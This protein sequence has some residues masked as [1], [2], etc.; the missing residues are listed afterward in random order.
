VDLL[1]S[2]L[3]FALLALCCGESRAWT[4][5]DI[6][7]VE[8]S[9]TGQVTLVIFGGTQCAPVDWAVQMAAAP[10]QRDYP[11][12]QVLLLFP[13]DTAAAVA[14]WRRRVPGASNTCPA[15]VFLLDEACESWW[16][17]GCRIPLTILYDV[18]GRPLRQWISYHPR[19]EIEP[20]LTR[21]LLDL[22]AS[23]SQFSILNS[24]FPRRSCAVAPGVVVSWRDTCLPWR[25]VTNRLD[26]LTCYQLTCP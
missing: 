4:V 26:G 5:R 11:D 9:P 10:L 7:G 25:L 17:S 14:D 19:G 2:L 21:Q 16:E 24:Q 23:N 22:R 15:G 13:C 3:L 20:M 12:T 1:K 6:D 8:R 18:R